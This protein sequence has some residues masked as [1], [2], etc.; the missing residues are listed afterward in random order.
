[1][2]K[3]AS[4]Y[5]EKLITENMRLVPYVLKRIGMIQSDPDFEDL[6]QTGYIG[7]IKAARTFNKD[8]SKFATYALTCIRNEIFMFFRKENK[9]IKI[10]SFQDDLP[11]NNSESDIT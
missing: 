5:S 7:L 9:N 8:K 4:N 3:N 2:S 11:S 6:M 10:I 1:M